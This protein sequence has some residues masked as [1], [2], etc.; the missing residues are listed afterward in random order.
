MYKFIFKKNIK[1]VYRISFELNT[2]TPHIYHLALRAL[3]QPFNFLLAFVL[4]G[5]TIQIPSLAGSNAQTQCTQMGHL[6]FSTPLLMFS[7]R[8]DHYIT[9]NFLELLC[10]VLIAV[11]CG[12]HRLWTQVVESLLS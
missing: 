10:D 8:E 1:S 2:Q 6:L 4:L 12:V 9:L 7:K 11:G 3:S 5:T